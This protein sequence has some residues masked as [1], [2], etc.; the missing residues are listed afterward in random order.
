MLKRVLTMSPIRIPHYAVILT[1]SLL[2]AC[3]GGKG[4]SVTSGAPPPPVVNTMAVTVDTGPAGATGAINHAYVTV[5]VCAPGNTTQCA[6]IDHVLLD[7][8]S[9]GLRL[10]RSVL[11]AG[12]VTLTAETD[13]QGRAIEEC[14]TFGG[15]QTWGPVALADVTMAGEVAAKLPVQ[16]MDDPPM[17]GASPPTT[18]PCG[19]GATNG[20]LINSVMGFGANGVLGVGVFAQDCGAACVSAAT[21][22]AAYYGCTSAGVCTA[23][24]VTLAEQ[25]T[26]PVAA[27][28]ADNN[29]IIV[30][31]PNLI[32]ANGDTSVQ[33]ELIFGIATQ[34]DN[35]LPASGLTVLGADATGDFT[36]TYNGATTLLPA[37]IDSGTDAY[38]F[39]ATIT[40]CSSSGNWGGYYCPA[41]APQNVFAVNTGAG[42]N[43]ATNTVN[44]A[45]A[46][47]NTFT[48]PAAGAAAFAGLAGGPGSTRFVWGMPFFYGRKVYI[49]IEQKVTGA[50]TGPYYA[51]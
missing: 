40:V 31:M 4:S 43:N 48:L 16:I 8:G 29:G 39:D 25:V 3:L 30:N 17:A 28:A 7:T 23:E 22:L 19:A 5:R 14:E 41:V 12:A 24:N 45:I 20:T 11:A 49:G 33:G 6:N 10:V 13:A 27:F 26:N 32:N 1:A 9:W 44:F 21:P 42:A 47:P 38:A 36:A 15:G 51:Y 50:F 2:S 46:D 35:A 34:A 37:L 18:S